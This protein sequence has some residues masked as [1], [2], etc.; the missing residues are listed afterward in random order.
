MQSFK[1]MSLKVFSLIM[2]SF[3]GLSSTAVRAE[4]LTKIEINA[5]GGAQVVNP[6]VVPPAAVGEVRTSRA[7]AGVHVGLRIIGLGTT[8]T[9]SGSGGL[10]GG[11]IDVQKNDGVTRVSGQAVTAGINGAA[12]MAIHPQLQS[13][14]CTVQFTPIDVKMNGGSSFE[15]S[16]GAFNPRGSYFIQAGGVCQLS[17]DSRV[18][19]GPV[20]GLTA[21][22]DPIL[23]T[24]TA[25][26]T[27]LSA[28]YVSK[29]GEFD[30]SATGKILGQKNDAQGLALGLNVD[31][32][33]NV[34]GP[35]QIGAHMGVEV[36]T[37]RKD[38]DGN[39]AITY[40]AD[41]D[42]VAVNAGV[43]AGFAW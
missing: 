41:K 19:F 2:V 4:P 21:A 33:F 11:V 3:A 16:L 17:E 31:G 12:L 26:E 23:G 34:L 8:T 29:K 37:D 40:V 13:G 25:V 20:V 42:V 32:K 22:I 10:D 14:G 15:P 28:K 1:G 6:T 39:Q 38:K 35:L 43:T 30:A 18:L 7:E 24:T 9:I 36:L 27:G 5:T